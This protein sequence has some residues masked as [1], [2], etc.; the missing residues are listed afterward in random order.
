MK[1]DWRWQLQ[2]QI[3]TLAQL[4]AVIPLTEDERAAVQ[5]TASRFRLGITPYYAGLMGTSP[6]DP[7]RRQAIPRM[8]ELDI[9][10][11]EQ[12]DPLAEEQYM[13]VPGLTRRYRDRALLFTTHTCA[14]YC[15]HCT[16]RRKVSDPSA[17]LRARQLD[18]ALAW[19]SEH[20][21]VEDVILSGGDPLS[22]SDTA[23][24][25][26]LGRLRSLPHPLV[27]RIGTRHPVT[28]PMRITEALCD[29]LR[30]HGPVFLM[31]HFNH[32][33]ECTEQAATALRRL[34]NAGCTVLNQSVLLK[35][36]NDDATVLAKLNRWLVHQ[37]ARPYRLYPCDFVEGTTQFRT[38]LARSLAIER[39][40]RRMD[41]LAVPELVL[42]LANGGGKV[43][44]A[45]GDAKGETWTF[46]TVDGQQVTTDSFGRPSDPPPQSPPHQ[47]PYVAYL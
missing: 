40:L 33:A 20:P 12:P 14:V 3:R 25:R 9:A 32:P 4:E 24:D 10:A 39:E 11:G 23:L 42:D 37:G 1:T 44:V 43:R 21:E 35:G 38:T 6:D 8:A 16:R 29:V 15:R 28:L 41:G 30:T 5:A 18:A 47:A 31:T 19:L 36:I 13:P 46:T 22:L 26:L 45:D 2:N 17:A 7:I 27:I 34:T